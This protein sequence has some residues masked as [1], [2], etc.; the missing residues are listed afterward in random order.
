MHLNE[1]LF[2]VHTLPCMAAHVGVFGRQSCDVGTCPIRGSDGWG[3]CQV[4]A[5]ELT[6]LFVQSGHVTSTWWVLQMILAELR[7]VYINQIQR[8]WSFIVFIWSSSLQRN[9]CFK[10]GGFASRFFL[11]GLLHDIDELNGIFWLYY[12]NSCRECPCLSLWVYFQ[13]RVW[14]ATEFLNVWYEFSAAMIFVF[15]TFARIIFF[16]FV[17]RFWYL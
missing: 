6:E 7:K 16:Y 13:D 17:L 2:T 5:T 1:N 8:S 4:D 11:C 3:T 10:F 9:E 15:L 12:S 14:L